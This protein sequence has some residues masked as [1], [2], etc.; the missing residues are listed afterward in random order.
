MNVRNVE[1]E[2]E[3]RREL[4]AGGNVS[5]EF[6]SRAVVVPFVSRAARDG[7]SDAGECVQ[8]SVAQEWDEGVSRQPGC[9]CVVQMRLAG[10]GAMMR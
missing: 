6:S 9:A 10:V 7:V 5:Y 3:V 1:G 2:T 8:D 4:I